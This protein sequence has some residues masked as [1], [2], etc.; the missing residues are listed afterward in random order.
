MKRML[1]TLA[2]IALFATPAL[3][4]GRSI[5][6]SYVEL[7]GPPEGVIGETVVVEMLAYN[8][9]TDVEWIADFII[10]WPGCV[11]VLDGWYVYEGD[12]PTFLLNFEAVESQ[13]RFT[14]GNE[15]WG[16][17][18]GGEFV[19]LFVELTLTEDCIPTTQIINYHLYGDIYGDPPHE[20]EGTFEWPVTG[21][22]PNEISTW[23]I[24]K[25][26]YR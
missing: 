21:G 18:Y 17:L 2:L 23:A 3:A 8:A 5:A 22:V 11:D 16:E 14:D 26:M 20:V 13:A 7:V 12:N 10:T 25:A 1:L 19:T 24:V 4:D 15:G 9:S 6:G